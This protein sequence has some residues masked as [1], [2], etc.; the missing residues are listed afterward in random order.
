MINNS[1]NLLF[2]NNIIYN[3][4]SGIDIKNLTLSEFAHNIFHRMDNFG[5]YALN[6]SICFFN[7][8]HGS[9]T[10]DESDNPVRGAVCL[11]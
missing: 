10:I 11:C 1:Q 9:N 6:S 5:I 4:D 8:T 2:S 7:S 3:G